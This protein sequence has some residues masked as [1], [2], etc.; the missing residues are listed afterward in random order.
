MEL[1]V[2]ATAKP[3]DGDAVKQRLMGF[4]STMLPDASA[5]RLEPSRA[6]A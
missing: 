6:S 3:A 1:T 2:I 5:G 4:V